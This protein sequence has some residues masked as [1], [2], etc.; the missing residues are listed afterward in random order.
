MSTAQ[1]TPISL[2][3]AGPFGAVRVRYAFDLAS[4]V[5][6]GM[7]ASLDAGQF[8]EG[9][10]SRLFLSVLKPGDTFID[11]GA[12]IGYFSMLAAAKVGPE[13]EVFAFEPSPGNYRHLVEHVALNGF[14][15]VIPMHLA[16]GDH[17]HVAALHLNADNDGGHAL[18]DVGVHRDNHKTRANPVAHPTFVTRLDHVLRGRPMASVRAIKLDVEGSEVLALRG[19]AETIARHRVPFIV[20]EVNRQGL[21]SLGTSETELRNMMKGFG[22]EVWL[23]QEAEPE[24]Q[25][26][27]ENTTVAG[28]FVFNLLFRRPGAAIGQDA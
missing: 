17:E 28:N 27:D 16:L 9:A 1:L 20:A 10:T 3:I 11:I 23:L 15:N 4:D 8:Y 21:E 5:Q 2:D 19:A 14:A 7:H 22:Y 13:G 24:L 26:L 18:W 12:H 6:R 25:P